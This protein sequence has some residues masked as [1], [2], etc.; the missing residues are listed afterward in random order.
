VWENVR[1]ADPSLD[2]TDEPTKDPNLQGGKRLDAVLGATFSPR[3][4]FFKG[5]QLLVQGDVPVMQSLDSPQVKSS[6]MLHV[7]WQWG[8]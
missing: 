1:G 2:P 6:Y 3:S 8:F 4:G 5:Q 7:A